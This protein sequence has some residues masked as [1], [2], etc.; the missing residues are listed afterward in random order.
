MVDLVLPACQ[1]TLSTWKNVISAN[2]LFVMYNGDF[3]T[4]ISNMFIQF[5]CA[6]LHV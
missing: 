4:R 1:K 3:Q 5:L 6:L 2:Q